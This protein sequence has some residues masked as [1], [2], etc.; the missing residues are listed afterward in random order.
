VRALDAHRLRFGCDRRHDTYANLLRD[1]RVTV[2]VL[3][4]LDV[5]FSISGR[6]RVVKEEMDILASDAVVEMQGRAGEGRHAPGSGRDRERRDILRLRRAARPATGVRRRGRARLNIDSVKLDAVVDAW[7]ELGALGELYPRVPPEAWEP[8]RE[9]YPELFAQTRWRL[10]CTCYLVRSG[11][12]TV[13]VDTG[14][15]PRGLWGWKAEREGGLLPGLAEL[16][17]EPTD[18][19]VVFLTHVHIDHVGWNADVDGVLLFSRSAAC[20]RARP[21]DGRAC[22]PPSRQVLP[23]LDR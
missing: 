2:C 3:A 4:P 10:P 11:G 12:R 13:L 14:V 18:V 17:V 5:A 22:E 15:G 20:G 7:G 1:P 8:Y 21:H 23:A 6:A 16:G 19:D 9:L